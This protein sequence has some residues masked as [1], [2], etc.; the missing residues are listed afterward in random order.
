[1]K[2]LAAFIAASF[3]LG[4]SAM[5]TPKH[6]VGKA[7]PTTGN[8]VCETTVSNSAPIVKSSKSSTPTGLCK[9]RIV[10]SRSRAKGKLDPCEVKYPC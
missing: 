3:L 9:R 1:M 4:A 7:H 2:F 10:H 5:A 8:Q 6:N